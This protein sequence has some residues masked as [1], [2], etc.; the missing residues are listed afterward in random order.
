[1]KELGLKP[2]VQW[3]TMFLTREESAHILPD[4][5]S[6]KMAAM[7]EPLASCVHAMYQKTPFTLHDTLLIMGPGPMGLLS[8]QIAKEI[9]AFCHCFWDY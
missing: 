2:M 9:G 8:L 6:Y 1:V 3:P 7:S 4:N 5:V